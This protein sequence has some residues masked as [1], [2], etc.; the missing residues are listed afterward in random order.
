MR[1]IRFRKDRGLWFVDF[2]DATGRR[3]RQTIGPGEEGRRLARK[4]LA[5]REAEAQLG[6][7]RLPAAQTARFGEYAEDWLRRSLARL[8]PKTVEL[9]E[10]LLTYHLLPAFGEMRLG[11]IARRDIEAYLAEA[12]GT[13]RPGRSAPSAPATINRG[14]AV[15]K[16]ILRDAEEHGHLT[17]NPA[18]RVKP[19]ANPDTDELHVLGPEEIGRLLDAA[20]EPWK[21]LYLAAVHTGLRRG[22]LLGLRWGDL[23]S[24]KG[25]LHVRRSRGRVREGDGYAVHEAL[26]KT[27]HSRRSVDL[28]P[29][30][31]EAL[32]ALPAGDDPNRDY[33][34]RSRTGGP[35]DPNNV[36]RAFKRHLTL[37][38][39]PEIRF[40]DLRH[41]H[42]S[43]LI[44]AG[45]HPKAIQS[46]LGHAS[47]T[48]TL[49]TYGHLMPSAFQGV[50]ERLDALLQGT[51]KA[52][53]AAGST[54]AGPARRLD[55][56]S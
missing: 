15:L 7:H 54:N 46:R 25:L 48:T 43:L 30:V 33:V 45:V 12:V 38:G 29:T 8:R 14:L 27:R 53:E 23:D 31:R 4:V 13:P 47:I 37:A 51:R 11:A 9:Y 6:I 34:F 26:P 36:D 2:V 32:L 24:T 55:P 16:V 17:E 50:G 22:E 41:T 44:A 10:D 3:I 56:A 5:Q 19:L 35:I 1:G 18:A 28:S 49:N 52:P 39:L 42:A 20:E 21:T 40:H